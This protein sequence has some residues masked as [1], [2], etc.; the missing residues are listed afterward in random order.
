LNPSPC[1]SPAHVQNKQNQNEK[2]IHMKW[3]KP[4]A[5]FEPTT[6]LIF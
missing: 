6:H 4:L 2:G 5:R 3:N 1:P